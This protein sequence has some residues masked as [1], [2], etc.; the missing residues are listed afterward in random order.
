MGDVARASTETKAIEH[1]T[2][3]VSAAITIG[4]DHPKLADSMRP[5]TKPP[6]PTVARKAPGKSRAAA[7]ADLLSG[8]FQIEMPTTA[9]ASGMLI[10]KTQRQDA[11]CTSH[12]PRTGPIAVVIAVKPDHVPMAAPRFFSS[13]EALIIERLPGT[14][15]AAP[16]P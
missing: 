7:C 3:A 14:S 1:A 15:S 6:R 5:P 8:I 12:P 13:K 4:L 9:I 10:R 2:P 16:T 11:C